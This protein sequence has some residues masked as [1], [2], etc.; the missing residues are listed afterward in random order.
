MREK[1][2]IIE[3]LEENSHYVFEDIY[4]FYRFYN[5]LSEEEKKSFL[6][7]EKQLTVFVI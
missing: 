2:K 6:F 3:Y 7:D 1:E 4:L 5:Y